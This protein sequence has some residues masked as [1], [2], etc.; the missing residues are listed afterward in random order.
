METEIFLITWDEFVVVSLN[1]F[2]PLCHLL[3]PSSEAASGSQILM[4]V[5]KQQCNNGSKD[6]LDLCIGQA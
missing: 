5:S 2:P 3:V 6:S 1:L 4:I